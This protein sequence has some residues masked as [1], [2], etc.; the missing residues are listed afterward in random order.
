MIRKIFLVF[1]VAVFTLF[2]CKESSVSKVKEENV[3]AAQKR[4]VESKNL[5]VI[6]FDKTEFDFGSIEEGRIVE[7]T[8]IVKNVGVLDL[9]ITDAKTTCGCTVP[10]L[11][12]EPIKKGETAEIKVKFNS[13]G[14]RNKQSKTITLIT[15]TIKGNEFL[16]IK[17]FVNPKSE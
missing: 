8:F 11:P 10:V 12:K 1:F 15:N 16:K 2:S 9:V 3:V 13:R 5:P 17:G 7:T 6:E 14:K 4:D